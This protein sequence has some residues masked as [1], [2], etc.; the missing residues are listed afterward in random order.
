MSVISAIEAVMVAIG[1]AETEI[2][3]A[4]TKREQQDKQLA[5]DIADAE[6][7]RPPDPEP[8]S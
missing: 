1:R 5:T 6:K 3:A 8:P 4:R 7:N 2:E